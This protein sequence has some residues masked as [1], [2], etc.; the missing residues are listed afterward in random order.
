MTRVFKERGELCVWIEIRKDGDLLLSG[1][2]LG[3]F[4]GADEYEYFI[5]VHPEDF[6]TIR[7][8][9]GGSPDE[10]IVELMCAHA[11]VITSVGEATWL[12][13]LGITYDFAN[14]F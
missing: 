1:Q 13:G 3:G 2:D 7:A 8:A 5:T 14:Y 11:D 9:L 12:K 10:D 6:P 4:M